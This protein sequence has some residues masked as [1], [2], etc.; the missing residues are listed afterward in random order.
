MSGQR[1]SC[2]KYKK[3]MDEYIRTH[4]PYAPSKPCDVDLRA[5][6]KYVKEKGLSSEDITPDIVELFT[7]STH[8]LD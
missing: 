5:F 8:A 2:S 1:K 6:T 3:E 7:H 4:S